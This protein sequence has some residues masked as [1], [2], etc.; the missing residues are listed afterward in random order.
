[1]ER[2]VGIGNSGST[3]VLTTIE[4]VVRIPCVV[5]GKAGAGGMGIQSVGLGGLARSAFVLEEV[6]NRA[7]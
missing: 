3:G 6:C 2:E 5:G 7:L 4:G 1:M